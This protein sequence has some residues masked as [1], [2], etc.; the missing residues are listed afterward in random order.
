MDLRAFK[1]SLNHDAPPEGLGRALQ[2]LWHEAKRI[3][4]YD[5]WDRETVHVACVWQGVTQGLKGCSN[6]ARVRIRVRAG[7]DII[8]REGSGSG[9]GM[10]QTVGEAH[11][12]AI[13]EAKTDAIKRALVTFGNPLWVGAL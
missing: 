2:A 13:K 6:V 3:F 1:A 4:G 10:G 9:H 11:E 5:A 12:S 8:V 7:D